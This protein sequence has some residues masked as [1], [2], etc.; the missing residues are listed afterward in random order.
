MKKNVIFDFNGTMIFDTPLHTRAWHNYMPAVI[1]RYLT[2]E[3]LDRYVIG[4]INNDIFRRFL[5]ADISQEEIDR[6]AY[7]KEAEYRRQCLLAPDIFHLVDGLE[8][9]LDYL[10]AEGYSMTIATGSPL[11]N[12]NL[13]LDHFNLR[14]WFSAEDIIY[15]DGTYPGKPAPD[16][17][18]LTM[19]RLGVKPE[20]CVVFEDSLGGVTAAHAAGIPTI[21]AL[22]EAGDER[23]YD[24]VGG[25]T[26]VIRNYRDFRD[27]PLE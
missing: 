14:R 1:G 5:G 24:R 27:L 2:Q 21:I 15:D 11:E 4:Q 16:I 22:N 17:Y 6:H 7:D 20:D 9:F 19:E 3:E 23:F 18:L 26:R 12:L 8:E 10:K 13:Y 25:V